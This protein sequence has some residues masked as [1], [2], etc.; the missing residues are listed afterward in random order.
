MKRP[1]VLLLCLL[2]SMV[3]W[4]QEPGVP[5]G[6][7]GEPGKC[8]SRNSNGETSW[9]AC[10][11]GGTIPPGAV[12]LIVSGTCGTTLGAGWTEEASL[13]GKFVLAT[14]AANSDI[15]GTGG[16]DSITPA[17]TNSAPN[18]IGNPL[19]SHQHGVGSYAN[20]AISAGTPAGTNGTVNFTPAG[21]VAAPAFTGT[22]GTVP[23]ETISGSSQAITAGT[24]AGTVA[25]PVFTGTALASH[26]HTSASTPSS[27][28]LVTGN[29]S[30]GVAVLTGGP[31]ITLTPAGTNSAPAFTGTAL[32]THLHG[33]GTYVNSTALFT[34]AGTNSA[35]A[36]TG[37]QG[38]VPA[39][40][41]T[42]SALATHNHTFSGSSEAVGA[43]IPSGSV[44][45]PAFTGTQF[46]NRPA[47][48]KVIFCKKD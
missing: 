33:V 17:G 9:V 20:T 15:G 22:Q 23:A 34:P 11:G 29:T 2:L 47:F 8:L 40:T 44:S 43:G 39:Q 27:P 48:V 37:T 32:G 28:K 30:S 5:V 18:F 46:D 31:S 7:S 3:G 21:T 26:T 19:G 1:I 4:A 16:T 41:F 6:S 24:P 12:L 13:N 36:F 10:G 14:V 35:P 42:G 45:A 38:V 25:A